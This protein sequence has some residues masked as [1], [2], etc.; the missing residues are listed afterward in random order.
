MKRSVT[1]TAGYKS[2]DKNCLYIQ[3]PQ[4]LQYTQQV[5]SILFAKHHINC[6]INAFGLEPLNPLDCFQKGTFST[7]EAVM[8]RW[9]KR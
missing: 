4:Q 8:E 7:T 1:T 3:C 6:H 2:S 9:G 5:G